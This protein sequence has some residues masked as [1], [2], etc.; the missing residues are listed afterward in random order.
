MD[1]RQIAEMRTKEHME[2][3]IVISFDVE[4]V[5]AALEDSGFEVSARNLCDV[6]EYIRNGSEGVETFAAAFRTLI[7]DA[8]TDLK[9]RRAGSPG[10][11]RRIS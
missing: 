4:Q 2:N 10:G 9:I 5:V 1:E 6:A 7:A 8:A 3:K 11:D